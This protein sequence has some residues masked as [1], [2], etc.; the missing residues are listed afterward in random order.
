MRRKVSFSKPGW[1]VGYRPR[2]EV[3]MVGGDTNHGNGAGKG[4]S[5][6]ASEERNPGSKRGTK[7]SYIIIN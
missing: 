4:I 7:T 3:M 5:V 6:L 2:V 1:S